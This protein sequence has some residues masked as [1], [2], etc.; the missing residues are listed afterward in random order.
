MTRV[1]VQQRCLEIDIGG[2]C[3]DLNIAFSPS[4]V[5]IYESAGMET[6]IPL[7]DIDKVRVRPRA[8]DS[9]IEVIDL[10]AATLPRLEVADPAGGL[11]MYGATGSVQLERQTPK[12]LILKGSSPDEIAQE[13]ARIS[14]F[15]SE[16]QRP[17]SWFERAQAAFLRFVGRDS[18]LGF[19]SWA[20]FGENVMQLCEGRTLGGLIARFLV[21]RR[22]ADIDRQ[23][24][25]KIKQVLQPGDILLRYQKGFPLDPFFVGIWQ[26]AGACV[27]SKATIVD[28]LSEGVGR[29][30]LERFAHADAVVVLRPYF[31]GDQKSEFLNYLQLQV[32]KAYNYNFNSRTVEHYCSGLVYH[33]LAHAG[34]APKTN[35]LIHP[36]RLLSLPG[37]AVVWTNRADL[38]SEVLPKSEQKRAA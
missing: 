17:K 11:V 25:E 7:R 1:E 12:A 23:D 21:K 9:L 5:R 4:S 10:A 33:A 18:K 15:H 20:E 13:D 3:A 28:A 16:I 8:E 2:P 35:E 34:M 36:D 14:E 31:W 24:L 29:R 22:Q 19:Y 30:S 38:V 27:D 26:H 6:E 37:L 32:G